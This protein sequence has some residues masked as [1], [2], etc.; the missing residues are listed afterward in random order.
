MTEQLQT[1][2]RKRPKPEERPEDELVPQREVGET[3][4]RVLE[5]IEGVL[6]EQA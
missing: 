1:Q 2:R 3:T 5:K 4:L 6:N